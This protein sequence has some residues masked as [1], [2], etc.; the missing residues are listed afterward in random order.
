MSFDPLGQK[1]HPP[2]PWPVMSGCRFVLII[3]DLCRTQGWMVVVYH[4]A[5]KTSA[6]GDNNI[7]Q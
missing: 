5:D 3:N 4:L 1:C 7:R 2:V 6:E